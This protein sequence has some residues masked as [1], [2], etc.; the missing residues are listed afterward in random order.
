MNV[1]TLFLNPRAGGGTAERRWTAVRPD[2]ERLVGPL[3][4]TLP[5]N[6]AGLDDA[7][8]HAF[9][10][11]E[12]RFIATGGDGTVNALLNSLLRFRTHPAFSQVA[13]GAVGLG[14]SNDFHKQSGGHSPAGVRWRIDFHRTRRQDVGRIDAATDRGRIRRYFI[15]NAS[16]GV[17]ADGNA[18]FNR[19]S[20][21][22]GLLKRLS[23]NTAISWAALSAILRHTD[24]EARVSFDGGDEGRVRISNLAVMK[25]P[26]ISGGMRAAIPV[27]ADGG[28]LGVWMEEGL[29]RVALLT[30]FI[31]LNSGWFSPTGTSTIGAYRSLRVRGTNLFP[32]EFDGEILH[33]SDVQFSLLDRAL[34]VCL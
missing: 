16:L 18:I 3:T 12:R 2:V 1:M 26:S 31:K 27:S 19:T 23:T 7:V 8:E 33:A 15:V 5:D 13:L 34:E 11:G 29:S 4:E 10:D 30:L 20:G 21:M 9:R 28:R 24:A 32:V 6:G 25:N 17:T 22:I 14:S